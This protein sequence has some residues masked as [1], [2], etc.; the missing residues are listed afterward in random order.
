MQVLTTNNKEQQNKRN[1][2]MNDRLNEDF[3]YL[4]W[5]FR[6]N[7]SDQEFAISTS[8]ATNDSVK[9]NRL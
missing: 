8:T 3:D 4:S 6:A 1:L 2:R 5:H 9:A 7:P